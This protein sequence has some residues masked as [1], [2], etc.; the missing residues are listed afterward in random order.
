MMMSRSA[1]RCRSDRTNVLMLNDDDVPSFT[2]KSSFALK[3]RMQQ[4]RVRYRHAGSFIGPTWDKR[5]YGLI[6]IDKL[7]EFVQ[8]CK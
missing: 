5:A 6:A 4:S 1:A 3:S 7:F 8:K 2:S